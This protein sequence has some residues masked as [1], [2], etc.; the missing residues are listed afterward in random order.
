MA[1]LTAAQWRV[2]AAIWLCFLARGLFYSCVTPLWEG[3]AEYGHYA[4][5][6][7]VSHGTLLPGRA[8]PLARDVEMSLRLAPLPRAVAG[9][10]FI[11][12]DEFWKLSPRD[13]EQRESGLHAIPAGADHLPAATA[14]TYEGRQPPLYYWLT[15][16]VYAVL[17]PLQLLDRVEV[18]RALN[19]LLASLSV[20]LAFLLAQATLRDDASALCAVSA[21]SAMPQMM[22][23]ISHVGSDGL[24]LVLATAIALLIVRARQEWDAAALGLLL[25][26]GLLTDWYFIALW[27]ACVLL[28]LPL[29]DDGP[30][31]RNTGADCGM[32]VR[33]GLDRDAA[34]LCHES[35]G[36]RG[37]AELDRGG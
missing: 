20:P 25:G 27:I 1:G 32:V 24:A 16:P 34:S 31:G 5:L 33:P 13:R 19:V 23:N 26:A 11:S 37:E 29:A 14:R 10:G 3:F 17:H 15:A 6:E 7:A 2:L 18:L 35:V 4:W 28:L 21:F 36:R 9:A 8:Q 22:F 12:H 30:G